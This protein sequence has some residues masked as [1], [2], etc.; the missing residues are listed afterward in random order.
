MAM[1][2]V[3]EETRGVRRYQVLQ[4][5]TD[6]FTVRLDHDSGTDRAEVWQRVRA[7]LADLLRANG[8]GCVRLR[9]AAEPPQ[10]NLRSRKLR[11]VLVSLAVAE[12][13]ADQRSELA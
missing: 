2:T 6:V 8:C 10:V 4:T 13:L 12:N 5:A 1:A 9:R 11:H 3:V 7:G